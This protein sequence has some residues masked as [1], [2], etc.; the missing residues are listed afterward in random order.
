[1][2]LNGFSSAL[3]V[4]NA[5]IKTLRLLDNAKKAVIIGAVAVCGFYAFKMLRK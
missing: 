3:K 5:S 2:Q 1:V 4:V